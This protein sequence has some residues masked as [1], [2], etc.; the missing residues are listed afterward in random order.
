MS[1]CSLKTVSVHSSVCICA[2]ICMSLCLSLSLSVFLCPCV[3]ICL[4]LCIHQMSLRL[5][6]SIYV[7]SSVCIH[8]VFSES[9]C[10]CICCCVERRFVFPAIHIQLLCFHRIWTTFRSAHLPQNSVDEGHQNLGSKHM[11]VF[12]HYSIHTYL[13]WPFTLITTYHMSHPTAF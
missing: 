1:R 6:L 13:C 10:L 4:L 11:C 3:F 7:Y 9:V 2:S 8:C 5:P 12:F